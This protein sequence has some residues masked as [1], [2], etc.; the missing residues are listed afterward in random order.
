LLLFFYWLDSGRYNPHQPHQKSMLVSCSEAAFE[1]ITGT[2]VVVF[3]LQNTKSIEMKNL[4]EVFYGILKLYTY[5]NFA[6]TF[7]RMFWSPF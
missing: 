2:C 1:E 7:Y 5:L 3:R 4:S 6:S